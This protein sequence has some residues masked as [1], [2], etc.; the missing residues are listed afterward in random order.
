M[1]LII[2]QIIIFHINYYLEEA[3]KHIKKFIILLIQEE[4]KFM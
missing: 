3:G 2:N 1:T 4:R